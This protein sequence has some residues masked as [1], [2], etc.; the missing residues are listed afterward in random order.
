MAKGRGTRAINR[1]GE[2]QKTGFM[3]ASVWCHFGARPSW[4]R[5]MLIRIRWP[6]A[7]DGW[8]KLVGARDIEQK[9]EAKG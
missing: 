2:G 1:G 9:V 7:L 3:L 8:N 5:R 6:T 4:R